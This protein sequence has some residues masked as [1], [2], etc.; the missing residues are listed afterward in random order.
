VE[1]T[2]KEQKIKLDEVSRIYPAAM[3]KT[4]KR[5]EVT[6]ISLEWID[7]LKTDEVEIVNFAIFVHKKDKNI[8]SFFYDTR[9]EL[10]KAFDNLSKQLN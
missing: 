10:L 7:T 2:L 9:K 5:D 8:L 3:V 4:G 1:F 6:Q